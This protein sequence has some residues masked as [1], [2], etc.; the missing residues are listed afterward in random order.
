MVK[1]RFLKLSVS[2]F[3]LFVLMLSPLSIQAGFAQGPQAGAA[4]KAPFM[5]SLAATWEGKGIVRYRIANR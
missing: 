4:G 1:Q 5:Y 2:F 3:V